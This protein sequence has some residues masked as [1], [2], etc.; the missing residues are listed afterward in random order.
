M[1]HH[2]AAVLPEEQSLLG[3]MYTTEEVGKMLKVSQRTVQDWIRS[4]TLTAVRY[5]RLLRIRQAD[6][7]A[8]GEVLNQHTTTSSED[9]SPSPAPVGAA[10]E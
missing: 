1:E 6:L 7:A 9:A 3:E 10:P 2:T 8:F 5:G 4:G